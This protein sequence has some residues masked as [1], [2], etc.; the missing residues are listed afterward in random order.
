MTSVIITLWKVAGFAAISGVLGAAAFFVAAPLATDASAVNG[1]SGQPGS[2]VETRFI[3]ADGNQ[4]TARYPLPTLSMVV[5]E[6]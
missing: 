4:I 1:Q 2:G 6:D 3:P 5:A